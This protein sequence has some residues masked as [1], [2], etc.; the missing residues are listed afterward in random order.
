MVNYSLMCAGLKN[1]KMMNN[2]TEN[3]EGA[4]CR[5]DRDSYKSGTGTRQEMWQGHD[6]RSV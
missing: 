5:G 1:G 6:H 4:S 3:S 2:R